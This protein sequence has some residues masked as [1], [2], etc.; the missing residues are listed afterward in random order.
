MTTR[1]NIGLT[2]KDIKALAKRGSL[3]VSIGG[4]PVTVETTDK[5]MVEVRNDRP[6]R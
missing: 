1:V 2:A 6:V 4:I 3:N 5:R